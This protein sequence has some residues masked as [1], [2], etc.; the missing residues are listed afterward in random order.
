MAPT[1]K[2]AEPTKPAE[3]AKA[4][5]HEEARLDTGGLKST[6]KSQ[7]T[8]QVGREKAPRWWEAEDAPPGS[9]KESLAVVENGRKVRV[10]G[11]THYHHLA[12]GRV[13]ASYTGGTHHTEPGE[14]GE[15]K[16]TRILAR[17]EG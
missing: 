8:E 2:P 7:L 4:P 11:P 10:Q 16:V 14:D 13:V 5:Q 17:Y 1:T 6:R 12:D 9:T 15:D 3:E